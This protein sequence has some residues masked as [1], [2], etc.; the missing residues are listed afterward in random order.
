MNNEA[1]SGFA[2]PLERAADGLQALAHAAQ[3]VAFGSIS[4]TAVVGDFQGADFL[5][6]AEAHAA[7]LCL[8]MA[9]DV[10]HRFAQREGKHSLLRRA[11]GNFR[12]VAIHSDAG[13]FQGST[14]PD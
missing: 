6:A 9:N 8:G 2:P 1:G 13:S 5:V 14:G 7:T 11:E 3:A 12:G 10:G 4:A